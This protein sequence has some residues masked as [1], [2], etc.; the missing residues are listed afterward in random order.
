MCDLSGVLAELRRAVT[1]LP[2]VTARFLNLRN[3]R[4]ALGTTGLIPTR[5]PDR[6]MSG[7]GHSRLSDIIFEIVGA[8]RYRDVIE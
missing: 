2:H 3:A 5:L 6:L 1:Y 4:T 7:G 8:S